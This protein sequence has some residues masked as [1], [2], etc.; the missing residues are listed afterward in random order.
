MQRGKI[1]VEGGE[2]KSKRGNGNFLPTSIN[3]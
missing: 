2:L 3:K 1:V